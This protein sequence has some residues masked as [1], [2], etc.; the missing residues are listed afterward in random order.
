MGIRSFWLGAAA[1]AALLTATGT[2]SAAPAG[3]LA[4]PRFGTWGVDL[5]GRAEGVR[6]GDDF[7]RFANG[8]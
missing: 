7:F 6:P 3:D 4:S 8:T 2:V 5:S 1:T